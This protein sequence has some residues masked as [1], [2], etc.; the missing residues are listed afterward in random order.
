MKDDQRQD[1]EDL[2]EGWIRDRCIRQRLN[3]DSAESSLEWLH[4]NGWDDLCGWHDTLQCGKNL[5][6]RGQASVRYGLTTHLQRTCQDRLGYGGNPVTEDLMRQTE[7]RILDVA[8]RNGVGRN[9]ND[10][11]TLALLQHHGIPTRLLDVT[12]NPAIA[13]YF[14]ACDRPE[15]DAALFIINSDKEP[16]EEL[17]SEALPWSGKVR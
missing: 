9:L 13:L 7:E 10:L 11:K 8:R 12:K 17:D 6:F 3:I 2:T 16:S 1:I 4:Q 14:A 15:Q 5:F